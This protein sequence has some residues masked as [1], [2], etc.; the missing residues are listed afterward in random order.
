MP[1]YRIFLTTSPL[2]T[3]LVSGY[4]KQTKERGDVDILILDRLTQKASIVDQIKTLSQLHEF[5]EL[6]DF[7]LQ[8][9][10]ESTTRP[11]FTK[12]LTRYLK[13]RPFFKQVY[14]FLFYLW[15]MKD[16]A[17]YKKM[18]LTSGVHQPV[19]M[20]VELYLQPLLRMNDPLRSVFKNAEVHYFEHGIGDYVD[21]LTEKGGGIFH[22]VFAS[23]Y[24]KYLQQLGERRFKILP[25]SQYFSS[26]EP[27][28]VLSFFPQLEQLRSLEGDIVLLLTQPLEDLG[29]DRAFWPYF[30]DKSLSKL[31]ESEHRTF[32]VKVHQ[33]Q[34]LDSVS[35]IV[36]RL[37][38]KGHRVVLLKEPSI[39]NICLE[40]MFG[41]IKEQVTHVIT[42]YSS[43]IFYLPKLYP[44]CKAEYWY[45]Y[46]SVKMF[47]RLTPMQYQIRWED[48]KKLSA[49]ICGGLAKEY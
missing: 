15:M 16:N 2:N 23:D 21:I 40:V 8:S 5:D 37:E 32:L 13:K 41:V 19:D 39:N 11:S 24:E 9:T 43:A 22:S 31:P 10:E 18:L 27:S 4:G 28:I 12:R 7:S 48:L 35:L 36:S 49:A 38:K 1:K 25:S 46:D 20:H 3:A 17:R 44:N 26:I 6:I 30:L 14:D 45:S 42:P 47:A 29:V 33:R 34:N